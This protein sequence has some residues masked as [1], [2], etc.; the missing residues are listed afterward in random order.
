MDIHMDLRVG[1]DE[2]FAFGTQSSVSCASSAGSFSTASNASSLP[3]PFTPT[4]GRSTPGL[5][6]TSMENDSVSYPPPGGFDLTPPTSAFGGYFPPDVKTESPRYV[7]HNDISPSLSRK[8]SMQATT[9]NFDYAPMLP[10]TIV[11][12]NHSLESANPQALGH[13]SFAD[14]I[15]SPPYPIS[16]PGYTLDDTSCEMSSMW[17]WPGDGSE[18]FFA[19]GNSPSSS[20]AEHLHSQRRGDLAPSY[21]ASHG[22]RRFNMEELQQKTTALHQI[23]HDHRVQVK[24][25]RMGHNRGLPGGIQRIPPGTHKC[26]VP[27]CPKPPFKR[28]EHLKR[29]I[30]TCHT[31]D[32]V[33]TTCPFCGRR[34]NRRDNYRQHLS[35]HTIKTRSIRRTDYFPEAQALYDEEMR[36]TKQRSHTKKKNPALKEEAFK[37][38]C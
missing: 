26:L 22:K 1:F 32:A 23:Q 12:Q 10:A 7:D 16:T 31:P 8:S 13:Y 3:D 11:S 2:D 19:R 20:P 28:Q 29:H 36:K 4:S 5:R 9:M 24:R 18:S 34:F 14:Q 27:G 15:T 6:F 33:R 25:Q 30:L 17:A 21:L 37:E 35:L 38:E